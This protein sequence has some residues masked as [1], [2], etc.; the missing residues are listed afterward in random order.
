M[1]LILNGVPWNATRVLGRTI[2]ILS[3]VIL[4]VG[5][6]PAVFRYRMGASKKK[7]F[8]YNHINEFYKKVDWT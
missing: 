8:S 7:W 1:E 2:K 6:I 3:V 4:L 5:V